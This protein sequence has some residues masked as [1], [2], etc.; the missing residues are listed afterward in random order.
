MLFQGTA[1]LKSQYRVVK[2]MAYRYVCQLCG[3]VIEDDTRDHVVTIVQ[4]HYTDTHGLQHETDV[5]TSGI[6]LDEKKIRSR[7]EE[8]E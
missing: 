5:K 2:G 4:R 6:E 3:D 8:I 7:I 1:L